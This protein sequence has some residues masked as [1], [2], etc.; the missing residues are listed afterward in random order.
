MTLVSARPSTSISTLA[1]GTHAVTAVYSGDVNN[2]GSTGALSG[3]EVVNSASTG[4][5]VGSSLNPSIY[6][7]LVTFTATINA[8]NNLFRGRNGRAKPM[9]VT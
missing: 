1:V 5:S 9:D 6:G 4:V 3:G 7:E 2:S 8:A